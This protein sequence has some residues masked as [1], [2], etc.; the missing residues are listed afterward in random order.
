MTLQ[1]RV[2]NVPIPA[3][4]L[5]IVE[6]EYRSEDRLVRGSIQQTL[7]DQTPVKDS[8]S[9]EFGPYRDIWYES[10]ARL[11]EASGVD[12]DD[13]SRFVTSRLEINRRSLPDQ[14]DKVDLQLRVC[15]GKALPSTLYGIDEVPGSDRSAG[16]P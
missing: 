3:G 15:V 4:N 6:G 12:G 9:L 5:C 1:D 2:W 10:E 16:A 7:P 14:A 13:Y 8:P 11:T